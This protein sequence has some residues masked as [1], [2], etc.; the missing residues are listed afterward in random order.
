MRTSSAIESLPSLNVMWRPGPGLFAS[1]SCSGDFNCVND[2]GYKQP[3]RA[4]ASVYNANVLF[5]AGLASTKDNDIAHP[6]CYRHSNSRYHPAIWRGLAQQAQGPHGGPC[7]G[8]CKPSSA[9]YQGRPSRP[10]SARVTFPFSMHYVACVAVSTC[11]LC[12][13][14]TCPA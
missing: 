10:G 3:R 11:A 8:P 2:R 6:H 4:R 13:H 1:S 7:P 9:Q 5:A 12:V 14:T